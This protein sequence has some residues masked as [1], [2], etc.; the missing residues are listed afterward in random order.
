MKAKMARWIIGFGLKAGGACILGGVLCILFL[1]GES[2]LQTA[3]WSLLAI[4]G[5]LLVVGFALGGISST[6]PVDDVRVVKAYPIVAMRSAMGTEGAFSGGAFLGI[7][8]MD[9]SVSPAECYTVMVPAADGGLTKMT[10]PADET[11]VYEGCA[12]DEARVE[13][14]VFESSNV[15]TYHV[16]KWKAEEGHVVEKGRATRIYVPTGSVT[17]TYKA[18]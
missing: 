8:Y 1:R 12:E 7:G 17:R 15:M 4:L 11:V 9:G 3:F 13:E 10:F 2:S 6:P 14:V 16:G 5:G 18:M